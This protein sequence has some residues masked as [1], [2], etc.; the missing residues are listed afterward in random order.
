MSIKRRL[1]KEIIPID[2]KQRKKTII[3]SLLLIIFLLGVNTFAWF[4]YISRADVSVSG[5]IISWDVNFTD[6]NGAIQKVEIE[7]TD[8]KPGMIPFEKTI[9]IINHSD[10]SAKVDFEI[11]EATLLGKD[12]LD[13]KT[14]EE[15]VNS[16][17]AEYPFVVNFITTTDELGIDEETTFQITVEWEYENSHYYK[18]TDFYTFDPGIDY[19]MISGGR[20]RIDSTVTSENFQSKIQ[21]GLYLK[22]DDAD[23]FYGHACGNY[24]KETGKPCLEMLMELKVTQAN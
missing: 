4:T 9:N 5:S 8:M 18:V 11:T 2:K 23:S 3:R 20:Y 16:L 19:Y 7:V 10:V 17:R 21:D 24:E 6:E 12:I 1:S 14:T 22:K 15:L 13:G